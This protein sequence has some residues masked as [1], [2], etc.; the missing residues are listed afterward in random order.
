MPA[1]DFRCTNCEEEFSLIYKSIKSYSEATPTCPNCQS[2]D[3]KRVIRDVNVPSSSRDFSRMDSQDML[4]VFE[5]GDSKQ[6]GQMFEQIGGT[7]P[8]MGAEY[9]EATKK[10]LK[11]ESLDSVESSL[12]EKSDAKAAK[13]EKKGKKT[14]TN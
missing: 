13:S 11:G 3:L 7:N 8:A 2:T 1:Y 12:Q 10:L 5:S 6:V 4:S 14:E 9:H